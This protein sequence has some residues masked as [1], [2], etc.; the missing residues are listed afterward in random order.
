MDSA[1]STWQKWDLHIHTPASFHWSDGKKWAAQTPAERDATCQRMIDRM[2]AL[3]TVVFCVMD[4]WTFDGYLGLR[5]YIERNSGVTMKRIF[6]GIELR[7]AAETDFRLNTH[8]LFDDSVLPEALGHF[9]SHL[10]MAGPDGRPVSRQNFI[11]TGRTYDE[12]K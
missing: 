12:G 8:V 11:D 6:P 4:Y 5:E 1:G 10:E 7:M 2:N 9:L 3:D